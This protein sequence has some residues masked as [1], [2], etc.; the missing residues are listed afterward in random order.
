MSSRFID[1]CK[2]LRE[3]QPYDF[4][5]V[6]NAYLKARYPN[7]TPW[8]SVNIPRTIAGTHDAFLIDDN[9]RIIAY[10]YGSSAE[11]WRSKLLSESDKEPGDAKKVAD[12]ARKKGV[13]VRQLIFCTTAALK[14]NIHF[15]R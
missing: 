15:L 14:F 1:I 4:E 7:L 9:G 13:K 12:F 8:Q 5:V 11:K 3:I 6:C 10:Q 2:K